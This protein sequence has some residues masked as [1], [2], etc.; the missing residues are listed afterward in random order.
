MLLDI[1]SYIGH[2]PFIQRTHNTLEGRLERMDRFGID[3]AVVSSL[4]G[5]FYK[6]PQSANEELHEAIR[7]KRAHADRFVPFAV[8][9]PIYASWKTHFNVCLQRMGMK[10]IRIYPKYHGYDL[11]DPTCIEL[12]KRS[13]DA[14]LPV[15][16]SLR[17]VDSRPSSWLD[18]S[19]K[20]EWALK[21]ALPVIRAVPDAKFIIVNVS[22]S[23]A[24]ADEDA[25]LLKKTDFVM[26]TS[27]RNIL[28]LGGLIR[29]YGKDKF[30]FGTHAPMLDEVTGLLRIESL[31][32]DEADAVAKEDLRSGNARRIL[33]M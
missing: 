6:N 4:N 25:A 8:I 16:V 28:D 27:G 32:D 2:W 29:T 30:G 1:N 10:G 7:S 14:G 11:T 24:L 17:M 15:A 5:V 13:R 9:N 26:D 3:V 33:R 21:D 12:V 18:L 20:T 23:T 19:R 31:R 22:N